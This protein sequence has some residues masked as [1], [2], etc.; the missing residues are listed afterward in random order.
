MLLTVR[1]SMDSD[2]VPGGIGKAEGLA[3]GFLL[4]Y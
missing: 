2:L 4:S 3:D 1:C